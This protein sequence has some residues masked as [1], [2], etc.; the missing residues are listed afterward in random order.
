MDITTR[1]LNYLRSHADLVELEIEAAKVIDDATREAHI[2][3]LVTTAVHSLGEKNVVIATSRT[4]IKGKDGEESLSISRKISSAVVEIVQKILERR[5]P[6][7]V[8]AKGGI[9]SSDVATKGLSIR[10]AT[11]IGPMLPG[12]VSLW[13]GQDGPAQGIPYIVFAGNVGDETSLA[14]VAEKLTR[15]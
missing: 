12:I 6:K 10:H 8:I 15:A 9:T 11:V 7:F 2:E 1:Q 5:P 3:D 4:V 13:S 14:E